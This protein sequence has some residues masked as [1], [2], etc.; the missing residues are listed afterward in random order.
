MKAMRLK[1][2][3]ISIAAIFLFSIKGTAC[4]NVECPPSEYLMFRVFDPASVTSIDSGIAQLP[5]SDDPEV[6]RYLL[7]ARSCEKLRKMRDSKWYYPTKKE[8]AVLSSLEDVLE[9]ALAYKGTKLKDRY[10]LQAARA[11]FSLQ[12]YREMTEW[13]SRIQK[14]IKDESIRRSI[15]GYVA[16]AMFRTGNEDKALE[17]YTAIGDLSSIIFCLKQQEGYAGDRTLLEYF[18]LHCPDDPYVLSILQDYVTRLEAYGDFHEKKGT[19]AA[20]YQMCISASQHSS[21]PAPWLYTAAFLKNQMGQ[22]Y[23][24]SNILTRAE[25]YTASTFLKE[26][27]RV[28]RILIDAQ[29]STYNHAYERQLLSDLAWLDEKICSNI[30]DEVIKTTADMTELKFGYSYYYWN[31]MMRKIVLGTVVPRMSEASKTA[32][33]LLLANYADNRLIMLV[34]KVAIQP[35][36]DE[37]VK[38]IALKEY[39]KSKYANYY[40]F[41]NHYFRILDNAPISSLTA[42]ESL[43]KN[44]SDPLEKFLCQRAY[45]N[46]DYLNDLIGTRY[47]REMKYDEALTYLERISSQYQACLNTSSYMDL[48]PFSCTAANYSSTSYK[49]DFARKMVD[50][51]TLIKICRDPDIVGEALIMKGLGI[52][53]S[54]TTCWALTHYSKSEYNP[55]YEDKYTVEKLKKADAIIDQGL[56]TIKN[57]ETAARYYR[58]FHRWKT[59]VEKYPETAVAKEIQSSC[60]NIVDYEQKYPQIR[61]TGHYMNR[62]CW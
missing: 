32:L 46:D 17:Y 3:I 36:W 49:L 1:V 8:D 50:Y 28:L 5:E 11:M 33:G 51:Q 4:S 9:E 12:R 57:I 31:D 29:I 30:T 25:Q 47:L 53:S 24:A 21:N 45:R 38:Y 56:E 60:D 42:Y 48:D 55:W 20:C 16:G 7:V 59:A 13:W 10:A 34:D 62:H 15:Q 37:P 44:G 19:T 26:S 14:D 27:M 40:D 23:V 61:E 43:L 6:R 22:P 39:R 52:R 18:T 35:R 54:F 58:D 2:F 41:S